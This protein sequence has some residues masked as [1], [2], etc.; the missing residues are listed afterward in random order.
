MTDQTRRFKNFIFVFFAMPL[1]LISFSQD[2][3][4]NQLKEVTISATRTEKNIFSAGRAVTVI[5][6]D[7]IEKSNYNSLAELLSQETGIYIPGTGQ[8]PGSNQSI[9]L[10][11]ANSNQTAIYMDGVRITDASTVNNTMDLSEI[12]LQDIEKIEILRGSHSTLFGSSAIGGVINISTRKANKPGASFRTGVSVG[13]FGSGTSLLNP[14]ANAGYKFSNGI[15]IGGM[16]D[17]MSVKGLDATIDTVTDL[18]IYKNRDKDDWIKL[19][20]GFNIGYQK[21]RTDVSVIY[22]Y[23]ESET[24]IDRSAFVDDH[25]YKLKFNRNLLSGSINREFSGGM[26][27]SFIAGASWNERHAINDSSIVSSLPDYDHQY[28]ED[29]YTGR[30]SNMDLV[31]QTKKNKWELVAGLART[32]EHMTAENYLYAAFYSDPFPPYIFESFNT[33]EDIDPKTETSSMYA[34]LDL[35]GSLISPGL[36]N[37]NL[38]TGIRYDAHDIF[39]E[40]ISFEINPSWKPGKRS[41]LYFSYSTGFNSPSLYQLFANSS[42]T[43]WDGSI[44]SEISLGNKLLEPETS[45]CS[46]IGFKQKFNK[47][48]IISLAIFNRE[49]KNTIEYAYLWNSRI[50]VEMIGTDFG[51]DDYRGDLYINAGTSTSY[52][53]E[54]NIQIQVLKHLR[55]GAGLSLLNGTISYSDTKQKNSELDSVH[56]QLYS[57]GQFLGTNEQQEYGLIRRPQTARADLTY[58]GIKKLRINLISQFIAEREDVFYDTQIKPQGA[59]NT[60]NVHSYLLFDLGLTYSISNQFLLSA[61]LENMLNEDYSEIRG[62]RTRGRGMYFKISYQINK[63]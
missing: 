43:P 60:I 30:T 13:N 4:K 18:S 1:P 37:I 51:R 52:G 58:T 49:V 28:A 17:H 50:P 3:L 54:I 48:D 32:N 10:R 46:E 34:Q 16:I 47:S 62:F 23:T 44:G 63:K 11:G 38:V 2:S 57:N 29:K 22:R 24:D 7:D 14:F 20:T 31:F 55:F 41:L 9:F 25:N 56:I 21:G 36:K 59:L 6:S 35:S 42:Y 12:S 5:S 53:A 26:K 15:F 8:T 45:V 39:K 40:Q 19:N 61:R 33:L 27:L